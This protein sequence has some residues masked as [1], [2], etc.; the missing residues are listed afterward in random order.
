[1]AVRG[2]GNLMISHS[3]ATVEAGVGPAEGMERD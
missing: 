2:I 1:M 3:R